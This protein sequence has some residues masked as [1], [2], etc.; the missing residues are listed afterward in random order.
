MRE[1]IP[2]A[3]MWYRTFAAYF[4]S[5]IW[6]S[7]CAHVINCA[8][9]RRPRN[10]GK[11]NAHREINW[12]AEMVLSAGR[13]KKAGQP[14]VAS[15]G[16]GESPPIAS[17]GARRKYH[18]AVTAIKLPITCQMLHRRRIM[19]PRMFAVLMDNC[20]R[21]QLNL[22]KFIG[23]ISDLTS[24]DSCWSHVA[25]QSVTNGPIG[26]CRRIGRPCGA[27]SPSCGL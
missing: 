20:L 4:F 17:L 9:E 16:R 27:K 5:S 8:T 26:R 18:P 12:R 24:S 1:S 23:V 10:S 25:R 13:A 7:Y 6:L 21:A 2:A 14:S 15:K 11:C 22:C 19:N 3:N